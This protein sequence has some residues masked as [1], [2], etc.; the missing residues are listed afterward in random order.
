M[1]VDGKRFVDVG[2]LMVD[3][4]PQNDSRCAVSAD[5]DQD[6]R[7]D[8]I[9]EEVQHGSDESMLR[10]MKN[11]SLDGNHWI[12]LNISGANKLAESVGLRV[13][14]QLPNGNALC[15]HATIGNGT[16]VQGPHSIH[17]GIGA[18]EKVA[19]IDLVWADGTKQRIDSPAIDRYHRIAK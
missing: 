19:S 17:F 11:A 5:L 10:V 3:A 4:D 7:M 1:R 18:A 16:G 6:G 13:T 15:H 2:Y 14:L 9:Y 12:G 8:L